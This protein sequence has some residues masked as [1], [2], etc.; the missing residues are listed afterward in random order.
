MYFRLPTQ[1]GDTPHS[2]PPALPGSTAEPQRAPRAG[3]THPSPPA[4]RKGTVT[5][6][7]KRCPPSRAAFRGAVA[8]ARAPTAVRPP[9]R[10]LTSLMS[11]GSGNPARS[12]PPGTALP[13]AATRRPLRSGAPRPAR[14]AP[15]NQRRARDEPPPPAPLPHPRG[16]GAPWRRRWRLRPWLRRGGVCPGPGGVPVPSGETRPRVLLLLLGRAGLEQNLP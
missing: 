12:N 1:Q 13:P 2:D 11:R 9:Q 7:A 6:N 4:L 3:S 14:L 15:A 5:V 16:R 10:P 8:V